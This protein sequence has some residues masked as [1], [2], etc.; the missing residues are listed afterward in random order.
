[1]YTPRVCSSANCQGQPLKWLAAITSLL[2]LAS[3][4]LCGDP[5]PAP[6]ARPQPWQVT[7]FLEDA[8]LQD[9]TVFVIDFEPDGTAWVAA[10]DGLYRYDGYRWDRFTTDHGLPSNY[11]RSVRVTRGGQLWVGT[12]RGAGV[13]DGENYDPRGSEA[14]LAGPRVRRI[15][16]DPDGTLWFACDRWPPSDVPAGLTRYRDGGW[17]S[18][19]V[20]DGL[21]SDYV[22]DVF[23]DGSGRHYVLTRSGLARFNEDG[24]LE[25]PIEQAGLEQCRNY[26]WSMVETPGGELV[27]ATEDWFCVLED[28]RWHV[29]PNEDP[30]IMLSQL[31]RTRDGT[32]LACTSEASATFA[33]WKNGRVVPIWTSGLD[34]RGGTQYIVEAPDGAIWLGGQSLLARWDRGGGEWRSF[35]EKAIP[36]LRDA[37]GGVWFAQNARVLRM[38]ED[39][40]THFPEAS[41]PLVLDASD[42]VWMRVEGGLARWG[43]DGVRQFTE[44][45]VGLADVR[46][47]RIDGAGTLWVVG[48]CGD[49]R[50]CAASF[51]GGDWT[52]HGLGDIKPTESVVFGTSDVGSGVWYVLK[53]KAAEQ[54]RLLRVDG[55]QVVDV[56]MP[57]P[58]RRYW[59]PNVQADRSR[60]LWLYGW[61]GL[62]RKELD[63]DAAEWQQV[64]E[65]P[66]RRVVD[67]VELGDEVW[68]S[69]EGTTGGTGGLTR[70]RDGNWTHFPIVSQFFGSRE[71]DDTLFFTHSAGVSIVVPGSAGMPTQVALPEPA[72]ITSIVP[73]PRGDLWLGSSEKVFHY[74][75]DGTPPQTVIVRG[76][77]SVRHDENVVLQVRGVERFGSSVRKAAFN[78]AVRLDDRPWDEFLPLSD[79]RVTVREADAGDH[80]VHVRVKDQGGDIDPTPAQWHFRVLPVPL[81][82]RGWFVPVVAAVFLTVLTLAG[83]SIVASRREMRQR[84]RQQKLEHEILGIAERERRRI[85]RDLHDVLG[86][87]LTGISFQCHV[88]RAMVAS[89]DA[90]SVERVEEIES[91]IRETIL[92]TRTLAYAFYPAEVDRGDLKTALG[93]LVTSAVKGFG[94]KCNYRHHG[95]PGEL[96]REQALNLYR[97]VQEALNNAMRHSGAE[98][99]DVELRQDDGAWIV[100]VRDDGCGFDSGRTAGGMGLRI[101]RYR[102]DLIGGELVID[103]RPGEGTTIRCAGGLLSGPGPDS[104]LVDI[105]Q[106]AKRLT[107]KNPEKTRVRALDLR[108]PH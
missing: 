88:L 18:W 2:L 30:R 68:F 7:S 53:D 27:V 62:Y 74:Q 102:A 10:N 73:G 64:T 31:T 67:V 71:A 98:T 52:A 86:Q 56:P 85:G 40:W 1:M 106:R 75:P 89:G 80:V 32:I 82:E 81:Q 36:R 43:V 16:E 42:G 63:A 3:P 55:T 66:G 24:T 6:D 44:S 84:R 87:R 90:S 37:D 60:R 8:G 54:Y 13:F 95:G 50:D 101:M 19:R 9:S 57:M 45:T 70:L 100:E 38:H 22:S 93:N 25:R 33:E 103:S 4:A 59:M 17:K 48:R 41:S 23:R 79:G 97:L 5:V 49:G 61:M 77:E 83:T 108:D 51:D 26:I 94:G 104:S 35:D 15:V 21:P 28:G 92:E 29:V 34:A 76:N 12:D 96:G 39:R 107:P 91:A 105:A 78:V 65:L 11:V 46:R 58:A 72:W 69:Y 14:H 20:E 99:I 47:L